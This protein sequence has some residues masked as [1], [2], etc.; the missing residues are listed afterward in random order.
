[1]L[2][3]IGVRVRSL[4][5]ELKPCKLSDLAEKENVT[6]GPFRKRS[7]DLRVR[8]LEIFLVLPLGSAV[9]LVKLPYHCASSLKCHTEA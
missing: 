9:S 6:L 2:S 1:M 5:R 3:L 8:K 7:K 4:V